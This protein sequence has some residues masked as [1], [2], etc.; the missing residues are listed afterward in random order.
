MSEQI[1]VLT[2]DD[3]SFEDIQIFLS[4][5]D[6]TS[7]LNKIKN[8][9]DNFRIEIFVKKNNGYVNGYVPSYQTILQSI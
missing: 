9:L 3:A 2:C 5:Y 6:A 7:V 4:I 8:N 1:Y